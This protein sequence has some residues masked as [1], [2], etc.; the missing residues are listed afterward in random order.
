VIDATALRRRQSP[1]VEA[2]VSKYMTVFDVR[3]R[4]ACSRMWITRQTANH[5]F[6]LPIR[7]GDSV[8]VRRRWLTS[9]VD[10]W[11]QQY[12]TGRVSSD[13]ARGP[14]RSTI[15]HATKGKHH[16]EVV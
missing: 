12:I 3:R 8:G 10:A 15:P 11:E 5:N 14:S 7:F 2:P 9:E 4:F 1:T 6:P 16:G 13:V